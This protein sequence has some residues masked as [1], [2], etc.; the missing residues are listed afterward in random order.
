MK[1]ACSRIYLLFIVNPLIRWLIRSTDLTAGN[2]LLVGKCIVCSGTKVFNQLQFLEN[3]SLAWSIILEFSQDLEVAIMGMKRKFVSRKDDSEEELD[4]MLL[5]E[6]EIRRPTRQDISG[7]F[8]FYGPSQISAV[9]KRK[10]IFSFPEPLFHFSTDKTS[11]WL[12]GSFS[13]Q[14]WVNRSAFKNTLHNSVALQFLS[15]T[16]FSLTEPPIL[17]TKSGLN[18]SKDLEGKDVEGMDMVGNQPQEVF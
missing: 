11:G 18:F 3:I 15:Q 16:C 8:F 1:S 7:C 5:H 10:T 12:V 4:P 2:Q 17:P 6:P 13:C 14:Y 9:P